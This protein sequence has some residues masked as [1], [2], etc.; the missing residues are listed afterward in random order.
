MTLP[1]PW[2]A[3]PPARDANFA[4]EE[5]VRYEWLAA[6]SMLVRCGRVYMAA[7]IWVVA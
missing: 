6:V 1:T 4:A 3:G 5:Y 7:A 2:P